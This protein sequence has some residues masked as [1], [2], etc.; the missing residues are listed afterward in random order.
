MASNSSGVR[1]A[2]FFDEEKVST[3]VLKFEY[4]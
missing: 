2:L 3:A 4:V 1:I